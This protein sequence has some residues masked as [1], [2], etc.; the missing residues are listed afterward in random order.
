MKSLGGKQKICKTQ[1]AFHENRQHEN[2]LSKTRLQ[3]GTHS[4]HSSI[5]EERDTTGIQD[6][7][8]ERHLYL[9]NANYWIY[10]LSYSR[11]RIIAVKNV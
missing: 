3:K 1:I 10:S 11:T 7:V 6:R 5:G 4:G 8:F 9:R 2:T